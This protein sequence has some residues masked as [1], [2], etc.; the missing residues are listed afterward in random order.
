MLHRHGLQFLPEN[1][2]LWSRDATILLEQGDNP[3]A[4]QAAEKALKLDPN[5]KQAMEAKV[6][7]EDGIKRSRQQ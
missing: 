1:A 6:S 2:T 3:Q 5:N 7:A 4:L